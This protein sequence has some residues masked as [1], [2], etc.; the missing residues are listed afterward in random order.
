MASFKAPLFAVIREEGLKGD[1][2]FKNKLGM[3]VSLAHFSA[4][5]EKS[6][7]TLTDAAGKS[8]ENS[9]ESFWLLIDFS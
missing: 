8:G 6:A 9:R 2:A 1:Y 7:K 3:F 4:K 5:Y